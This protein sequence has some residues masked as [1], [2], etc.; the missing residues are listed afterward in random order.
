MLPLRLS[1]CLH[2]QPLPSLVV[3]AA[4]IRVKALNVPTAL[5]TGQIIKAGIAVAVG[6]AAIAR[7]DYPHAFFFRVW[8]K[9]G[10][11][12]FASAG[13]RCWHRVTPLLFVKMQRH[14]LFNTIAKFDAVQ[15]LVLKG[16]NQ[17]DV[18]EHILQ[19]AQEFLFV[20]FTFC[21]AHRLT[22]LPLPAP[23]KPQ[24]PAPA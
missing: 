12:L 16:F 14:L 24:Q 5:D 23:P 22:S 11:S 20:L 17:L 7:R 2:S 18:A 10:A 3:A 15:R 19:F 13:F 21:F 8:L 4:H 6:K 9:C 1:F